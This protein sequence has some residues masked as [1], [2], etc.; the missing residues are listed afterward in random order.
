M[1]MVL[2]APPTIFLMFFTLFFLG[3]RLL[4]RYSLRG[5]KGGNKTD[6]YACGQRNIENYIN[7]DYSEFFPF[8]FFFTIM[9]VLVL[10]VATAPRDALL[11]PITFIISSILSMVIIFRR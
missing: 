11:L 7:P 2:F 4:S 1:A 3:S 5:I 9:H 6:S 10:V 8:A